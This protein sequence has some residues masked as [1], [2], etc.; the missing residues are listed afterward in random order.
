MIAACFHLCLNIFNGCR[1][2]LLAP[3]RAVGFYTLTLRPHVRTT[4]CRQH[5]FPS[6]PP[7]YITLIHSP[8]DSP[9][10]SAYS[11]N[12]DIR[13]PRIPPHISCWINYDS[14]LY[15]NC[16]KSMRKAR[17]DDTP[18]SSPTIRS[19]VY[20]SVHDAASTT[21]TSF[22][23]PST[24]IDFLFRHARHLR[25]LTE[26]RHAHTNPVVSNCSPVASPSLA[27]PPHLYQL[28]CRCTS[29]FH[30]ITPPLHHLANPR[31][32][33]AAGKA[34]LSCANNV[35][36]T[37][38][39]HQLTQLCVVKCA[40]HTHTNCVCVACPYGTHGTMPWLPWEVQEPK[41]FTSS[42]DMPPPPVAFPAVK[43]SPSSGCATACGVPILRTAVLSTTTGDAQRAM[44]SSYGN[45]M[46]TL[47]LRFVEG[48]YGG[49]LHPSLH[50][51]PS[52]S[53]LLPL[54]VSD[55]ENGTT[56]LS[57]GDG[58]DCCQARRSVSLRPVPCPAPAHLSEALKPKQLSP[59]LERLSCGM[60][61]ARSQFRHLI[62]SS[63]IVPDLPRACVHM[64]DPGYE[65]TV[66]EAERSRRGLR[67]VGANK[68][69]TFV[70]HY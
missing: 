43:P 57:N 70:I 13:T 63:T 16:R 9:A 64:L 37:S 35:V 23:P 20:L 53:M 50:A 26:H 51:H 48:C 59:G 39:S 31:V 58:N 49:P 7:S 52:L 68:Y 38:N 8:F 47:G 55:H 32:P 44:S 22:P 17:I 1:V 19:S 40:T 69:V 62:P 54:W 34:W 28:T 4:P 3:P 11:F 25:L 45:D 18:T 27:D 65:G 24:L 42:V 66:A 10:T 29:A 33:L 30:Y 56:L 6:V 60:N 5:V 14:S 2:Q 67:T 12:S 21:T 36:S 46:G 61:P 15:C 41:K